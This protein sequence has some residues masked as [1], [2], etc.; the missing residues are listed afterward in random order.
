[1]PALRDFSPGRGSEGGRGGIPTLSPYRTNEAAIAFSISILLLLLL[2][3]STAAACSF[4]SWSTSPPIV[5]VVGF[6]TNCYLNGTYRTRFSD[7]IMF[8][9][10]VSTVFRGF[11][12]PPTMRTD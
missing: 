3:T 4:L 11:V 6:E 2:E 1:M 10:D 9:P 5:V 12:C 8:D 7:Q